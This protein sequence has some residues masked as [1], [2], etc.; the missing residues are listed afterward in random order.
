MA[1]T[2]LKMTIEQAHAEV[3]TAWGIAYSPEAMAHAVASLKD[4]ELG[5]QIN[6]F[7]ARMCFR[8]IYFPQM[9]ILAWLKLIS[10][11]RRTIGSLVK[12]GFTKWGNRS[13]EVPV[14]VSGD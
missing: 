8:G 6:I 12:A 9:G 7:V 11:N 5:Y 3:K 2:P 14:Q 10:Q 1:H 13:V 4:Q